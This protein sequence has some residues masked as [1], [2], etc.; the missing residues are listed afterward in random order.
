[1][2]I[3]KTAV[4][5]NSDLN[6]GASMKPYKSSKLIILSEEKDDVM[7]IQKPSYEK[8]KI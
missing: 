1:M 3:I 2:K 5:K 7:N 4:K 6:G 8:K